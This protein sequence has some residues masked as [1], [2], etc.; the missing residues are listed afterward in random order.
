MRHRV[1]EEKLRGNW[2]EYMQKALTVKMLHATKFYAIAYVELR[3][4]CCPYALIT[5]GLYRVF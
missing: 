5:T 1:L 4:H 3:S 2:T